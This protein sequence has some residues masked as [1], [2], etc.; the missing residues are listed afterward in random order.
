M[1]WYSAN[2]SISTA[3]R[4]P[5]QKLRVNT[6]THFWSGLS[7]MGWSRTIVKT[8]ATLTLDASHPIQPVGQVQ[9][10]TTLAKYKVRITRYSVTSGIRMFCASTFTA[11]GYFGWRSNASRSR[12]TPP[13]KN[14]M[15]NTNASVN[16][17]RAE[18]SGAAGTAE[19]FPQREQRRSEAD[20]EAARRDR[21]RQRAHE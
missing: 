18:P 16:Q 17:R 1:R 20:E 7:A 19:Q 9:V 8:P 2:Q 3:G 10:A 14:H 15:P 4:M 13:R 5:T 11:A 21:R 6:P 12:G